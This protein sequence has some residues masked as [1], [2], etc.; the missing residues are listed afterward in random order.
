MV[1]GQKGPEGATFST[2]RETES[3][4]ITAPV[5]KKEMEKHACCRKN[6]CGMGNK[7]GKPFRLKDNT[8]HKIKECRRSSKEEKKWGKNCLK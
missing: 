6:R 3:L 2:Q 1:G 4:E 8:C 7:R 5:R